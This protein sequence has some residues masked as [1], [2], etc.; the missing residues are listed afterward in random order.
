VQRRGD[1]TAIQRFA[2]HEEYGVQ[3]D[4]RSSSVQLLRALYFNR[5][6]VL[7]L[8]MAILSIL[9]IVQSA[10]TKGSV[11]QFWLGLGTAT[12]ATTGYSFVQ[13]LLTTRQFDSFLSNAI[14][15]DIQQ[16]MGQMQATYMPVAT[17]PA[18]E[19][20]N[21]GF[22]LDLNK[23]MSASSRYMFRGMSARYAVARLSL[24]H[25]PPREI[26]LIVA[27][28]TK[29]AAVDSRARHDAAGQGDAAFERARQDIL[30]GIQMAIAGAYIN[31]RRYDRIEFGLTSVPYVD[32]IEICD[33]AIFISRFSEDGTAR[34]PSTVIFGRDSLIYQMLYRDC[35]SVL[36]SPYVRR[37][38]LLG[39]LSEEDFLGKLGAF[40]ISMTS[41][42]WAEMKRKFE[43]FREQVRSQLM[44]S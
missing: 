23:A 44:P 33:D 39:D 16:S 22:N 13:I 19:T 9:V 17:Y 18:L 40:G 11:S 4:Q 38:E 24:L 7:F 2:G 12:I 15:A 42:R 34:F 1:T 26:A 3:D 6:G 30:D 28:P 32:R 20:A 10:R 37:L 29:P 35:S 31:R 43:D 14:K 25:R 41:E 8:F 36:A 21:R 27:D 5:T